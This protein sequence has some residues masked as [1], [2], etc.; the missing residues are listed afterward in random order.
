[1]Q[2]MLATT[3]GDLQRAGRWSERVQGKEAGEQASRPGHDV[4]PGVLLNQ[5]FDF[6]GEGLCP[7]QKGAIV[8]QREEMREEVEQRT[9]PGKGANTPGCLEGRTPGDLLLKREQCLIRE[10]QVPRISGELRQVAEKEDDPWQPIVQVHSSR[11]YLPDRPSLA[12]AH[13][14]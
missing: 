8:S 5:R 10:L 9:E 1:R 7:V 3:D 13:G 6:F 2:Q 4:E 14:V 12:F 11:L